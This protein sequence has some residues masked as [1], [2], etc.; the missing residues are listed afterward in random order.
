MSR[1]EKWLLSMLT[2]VVGTSGL[3]YLW[4]KYFMTS[5]DPFA[6]VNHPWQPY[7]LYAHVLSSPALLLVFGMV[8]TSHVA[9][10]IGAGQRYS[11]RSGLA[12]VWSFVT[13][14]ASG[15][16]LQVITGEW[17]HRAMVVIHIASGSVFLLMFGAHLVISLRHQYRERRSARLRSAA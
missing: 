6:V 7:V 17:L 15:Y 11:R 16:L 10:K 1:V 3:A 13:M 4:M 2:A 9:G 12:S 8:W 5:D 14:A